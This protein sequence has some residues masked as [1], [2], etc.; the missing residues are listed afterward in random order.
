MAGSN[1]D[2][3]NSVNMKKILIFVIISIFAMQLLI[4]PS[5]ADV[6]YDDVY[7]LICK[8]GIC[9]TQFHV[10]RQDDF[11]SLD[12]QHIV[13]ASDS[14]SMIISDFACIDIAPDTR[15]KAGGRIMLEEGSVGIQCVNNEFQLETP[16]EIV[17][18]HEGTKAAV[19][20]DDYGNAFNYCIEG[21]VRLVS[22]K[23]NEEITLN[24]GEYIAITVKKGI[25]IL[26]EVKSDDVDKLNID[27]TA[28]DGD[29]MN[30]LSGK[31]QAK[32]I[33]VIEYAFDSEGNI[34]EISTNSV[35][36][37]VNVSDDYISRVLYIDCD[38]EDAEIAVY[39]SDF[40]LVG[41]NSRK[42]GTLKPNVHIEGDA[43]SEFYICIMS[44]KDANYYLSNE[45]YVSVYDRAF[46]L[47]KKI[48]LP[49]CIAM[50]I[51]IIYAL[52]KNKTKKKPTF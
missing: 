6:E 38:L 26:K 51:F 45:K 49:A 20:V 43:D 48:L 39:D 15:M 11:C 34:A 42:I 14:S 3:R 37:V 47:I 52:I 32:E 40:N 5:F 25:R 2:E 22:K 8:K 10:M 21:S 46:D 12:S 24:A 36:K 44:G 16:T 50:I 30:M 19:H 41:K 1:S 9:F 35:Y 17:Y 31:N 7:M 23:D 28:L 4:M 13:T 29:I 33:G 27:F 18:A